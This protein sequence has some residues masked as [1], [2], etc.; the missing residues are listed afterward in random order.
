MKCMREY[1]IINVISL[2]DSAQPP[3]SHR[4][5]PR[6][7]SALALPLFIMMG[8]PFT[9]DQLKRGAVLYIGGT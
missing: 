2:P 7:R 6:L 8:H 1:E 3:P 5:S 4:F 9:L